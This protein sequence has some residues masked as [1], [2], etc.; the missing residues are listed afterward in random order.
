MFGLFKKNGAHAQK[1]LES[2]IENLCEELENAYLSRDSAKT[3]VIEARSG[4]NR[5]IADVREDCQ[6]EIDGFIVKINDLERELTKLKADNSN[7]TKI[8]VAEHKADIDAVKLASE[9]SELAYKI[10][11][12]KEVQEEKEEEITELKNENDNLVIESA[13]F[14][15]LYQGTL[16]LVDSLKEQLNSSNKLIESLIGKTPSVDVK[17]STPTTVIG[18]SI[19]KSK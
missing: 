16:V 8:L 3:D 19:E 6:Y 10:R 11:I 17:V 14:S 5:K 4:M 13:K 2:R 7:N 12:K 15:G 1:I 9:A 18:Q